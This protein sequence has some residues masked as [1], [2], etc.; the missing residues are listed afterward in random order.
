MN[1]YNLFHC[2]QK[3]FKINFY[4]VS[5]QVDRWLSNSQEILEIAQKKKRV[6][7]GN[8]RGGTYSHM[9]KLISRLVATVGTSSVKLS[10][11]HNC[12]WAIT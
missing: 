1:K 6:I 4:S 12:V 8:S 10:F 3:L 9:I 7:T 2:N 11:T 5:P